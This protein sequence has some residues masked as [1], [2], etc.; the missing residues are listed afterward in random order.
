MLWNDVK[1]A[2]LPVNC[3]HKITFERREH[4]SECQKGK[5]ILKKTIS[6]FV[7]MLFS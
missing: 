6:V 4:V 2:F 1:N 5:R 3:L 7:R